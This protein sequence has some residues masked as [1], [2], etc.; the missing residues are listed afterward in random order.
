MFC[1]MVGVSLELGD[2]EDELVDTDEENT[3]PFHPTREWQTVKKGTKKIEQFCQTYYYSVHVFFDIL[4][5]H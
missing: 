2:G 3:D 4:E 1:Y 5:T